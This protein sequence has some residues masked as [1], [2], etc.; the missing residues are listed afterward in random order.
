MAGRLQR[1]LLCPAPGS[2]TDTGPV[3][4][5]VAPGVSRD[6]RGAS[7]SARTLIL[8]AKL[9]RRS[10]VP[11]PRPIRLPD[12]PV[13]TIAFIYFWPACMFFFLRLETVI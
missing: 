8:G 3:R 9:N 13:F 1:T 12:A 10:H 7:Y 11:R 6:G 2:G 4:D 5:L